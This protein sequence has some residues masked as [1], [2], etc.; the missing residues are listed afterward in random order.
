M[1]VFEPWV[2]PHELTNTG[3]HNTPH[4]TLDKSWMVVCICNVFIL[5]SILGWRRARR[6]NLRR[7]E[8]IWQWFAMKDLTDWC[9]QWFSI[10]YIYIYIM[11][12]PTSRIKIA[13]LGKSQQLPCNMRRQAKQQSLEVAWIRKLWSHA[14]HF[15]QTLVVFLSHP[16]RWASIKCYVNEFLFLR[17]PHT[18]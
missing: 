7:G 8:W 5:G 4:G 6:I 1:V 10:I 3:I 12:P 13:T 16:C 2:L 11:L 9:L 18:W 15:H 14:L 17:G